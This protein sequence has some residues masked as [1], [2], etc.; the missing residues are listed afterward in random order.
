MYKATLTD[1]T[2]NGLLAAL[3]DAI[4]SRVSENSLLQDDDSFD[5]DVAANRAAI[6]EYEAL[7][8]ILETFVTE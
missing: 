4:D 5:E 1:Q 7:E 3:N 8:R 6:A 2:V